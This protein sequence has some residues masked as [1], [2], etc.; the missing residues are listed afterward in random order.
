MCLICRQY[1]CHSRCP[2]YVS[3]KARHYCSF[4]GEGIYYGEAYIENQDGEFRHYDC[5]YGITDLLE[6]LEYEIKTMEDD[7]GEDY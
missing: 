4:C 1:P 5:F 7:Y 2:N 3:P 6:W